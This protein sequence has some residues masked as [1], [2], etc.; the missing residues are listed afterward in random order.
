MNRE[1]F[2]LAYTKDRHSSIR[3]LY[4]ETFTLGSFRRDLDFKG[5]QLRAVNV[6][7]PV[8]A[9][10][11][12]D[13]DI[14]CID[15]RVLTEDG[16]QPHQFTGKADK[17]LMETHPFPAAVRRSVILAD[18]LRTEFTDICAQLFTETWTPAP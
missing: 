8:V 9:L 18:Q 17:R 15:A 4:Q 16:F 7:C 10:Y 12:L 13:L 2:D 11:V 3:V 6:L 14:L 1:Q 5:D